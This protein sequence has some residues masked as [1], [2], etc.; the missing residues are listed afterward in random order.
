MNLTPSTQLEPVGKSGLGSRCAQMILLYSAL[1]LLTLMT[2]L[3]GD[4][5]KSPAVDVSGLAEL[6]VLHDARKMPLDSYARQLLLSWSGRD[7]FTG[8]KSHPDVKEDKE[9]A[10]E[11]FCR[12][13]FD[14]ETTERDKIFQIDDPAVLVALGLDVKEKRRRYSHKQLEPGL[15][16][17]MELAR[18]ASG[19]HK[20]DMQRI[21][22][23]FLRIYRNLA[24]YRALTDTMSFADS[25]ANFEIRDP[26]LRKKFGIPDS[27]TEFSYLDILDHVETIG[28]YMMAS[29][30]ADISEATRNEASRLAQEAFVFRIINRAAALAHPSVTHDARRDAQGRYNSDRLDAGLAALESPVLMLARMQISDG[31]RQELASR[32]QR[33]YFIQDLLQR[34]GPMEAKTHQVDFPFDALLNDPHAE[35]EIWYSPQEAIG[36]AGPDRPLDQAAIRLGKM[37]R[38]YRAGDQDGLHDAMEKHMQFI[39]SRKRRSDTDL[40]KNR[41]EVA[42]NNMNLFFYTKTLYFL[43]FL[44]GFFGVLMQSPRLRMV[45]IGIILAAIVLHTAAVGL[46]VYITGRPPVTNLYGTFPFVSLVAVIIGLVAE[47]LSRVG[48]AAMSCSLIGW[49]LLHLAGVFALDGSDTM[50]KVMPVLNSQFWLSTHVLSVLMGYGGVFLAGRIGHFYLIFL[51]LKRHKKKRLQDMYRVMSGVLGFGLTFAF[52]GTMLGGIWADQSWGRFWGWDPKENG[53]ILIVL[54]VAMMYHA[55]L[56]GMVRETGMAALS[57]LGCIVVMLAWLGVNVLGVGLHS[58]GFTSGAAMGL[59]YYIGAELL[60]LFGILVALKVRG[61]PDSP[62]A[63]QPVRAT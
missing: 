6:P 25:D 21:D 14:S 56:G 19:L 2:A 4:E 10:L 42:Y 27:Q 8:K 29:N 45:C 34:G 35:E 9:S 18:N 59:Y 30:R 47:R 43:A 52:L 12:L 3:A 61:G 11:F 20:S 62:R 22:S 63:R 38:A 13:L 41:I 40:D 44:V 48:I 5:A 53:A 36:L 37:A 60:F 1:S 54:W 24:M 50:G 51:V 17:L 15:G 7:Y 33:L 31:L 57:V 28:E 49:I 26:F 58:Y 16:K 46:R 55:K 32:F 23:E 39:G